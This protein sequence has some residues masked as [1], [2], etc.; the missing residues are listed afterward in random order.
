MP[1]VLPDRPEFDG[2]GKPYAEGLL[3]D[4]VDSHR[5]DARRI[6][7]YRQHANRVAVELLLEWS[8]TGGWYRPITLRSILREAVANVQG[9]AA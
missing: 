9:D 7:L 2:D 3:A 5:K 4:T 6:A 8:A 1:T